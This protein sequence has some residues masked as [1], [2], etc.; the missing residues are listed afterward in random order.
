MTSIKNQINIL[1][2][3]LQETTDDTIHTS[4]TD[5]I[6]KNTSIDIQYNVNLYHIS[7]CI[8]AYF[9]K[10]LQTYKYLNIFHY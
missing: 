2:Q 10:A 1:T 8:L 4:A 3:L 9:N 7:S 5:Y 6:D